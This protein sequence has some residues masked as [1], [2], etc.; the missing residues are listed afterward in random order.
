MWFFNFPFFILCKLAISFTQGLLKCCVLQVLNN[1]GLKVFSSNYG[2]SNDYF[3]YI[4]FGA[5]WERPIDK[6]LYY[7]ELMTQLKI[8]PYF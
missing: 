8:A 3:L 2:W 7:Y 6:E 1:E 4:D 5:N